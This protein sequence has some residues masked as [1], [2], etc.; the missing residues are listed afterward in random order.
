MSGLMKNFM[1]RFTDLITVEKQRGRQLRGKK[2]F[3]LAVGA[4]KELPEGFEI[5]FRLTSEY[6]KMTYLGAIYYAANATNTGD[7][8]QEHIKSFVQQI[9]WQL[10]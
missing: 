9:E 5:P 3:L 1:D 6:F 7:E 2:T 10:H 4:D 8:W